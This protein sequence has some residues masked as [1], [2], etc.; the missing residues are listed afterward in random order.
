MQNHT[1]IAIG[2]LRDSCLSVPKHV[3]F[4]KILDVIG[5][6]RWRALTARPLTEFFNIVIPIQITL[7]LDLSVYRP[8]LNML[9]LSGWSFR[10]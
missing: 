5:A 8:L 10:K 1:Y 9:M 6:E 4:T 2:L 3:L 7:L